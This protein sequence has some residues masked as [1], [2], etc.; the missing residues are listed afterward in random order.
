MWHG[1]Q[2]CRCNV[3]KSAV[4]RP[5]PNAVRYYLVVLDGVTIVG[6]KVLVV[7][8]ISL[9]DVAVAVNLIIYL[10]LY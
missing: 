9:G 8:F 7:G 6:V 5:Y 4:N 3:A 1:I 2:L 10:S